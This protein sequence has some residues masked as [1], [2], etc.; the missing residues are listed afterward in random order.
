MSAMLEEMKGLAIATSAIPPMQDDLNDLGAAVD[1]IIDQSED[2]LHP[3]T[4][5]KI[6]E[7]LELGRGL[8]ATLE[9]IMRQYPQVSADPKAKKAANFL[10][11]TYRGKAME[12]SQILAEITTPLDDEEDEPDLS[13]VVPMPANGIAP[14]NENDDEDQDD[15]GDDAEDEE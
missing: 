4:A 7:A 13:N 10:I 14:S 15:D 12:V 9:L 2:V 8:A 1:E 11:K 3:E 5:T 6:N